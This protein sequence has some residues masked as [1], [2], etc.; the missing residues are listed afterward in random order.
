MEW[1]FNLIFPLLAFFFSMFGTRYLIGYLTS[2]DI[3]DR[4]NI[5]SS[6]VQPTPRGGGIAVMSSL[7]LIWLVV[8]IVEGAE[9]VEVITIVGISMILAGTSLLDDLKG[10]SASLRFAVHLF[11]VST[12]LYFVPFPGLIFGGIL[13]SEWDLI[14]TAVLWVW[15]INL[16]NF[17]DGI[18]GLASVEAIAISIGIFVIVRK[19]GFDEK[20][21]IL[22]LSIG[23]ALLGFLRWNWH[24]AKIFL[25]DVGSIPLGFVLGW[26]LL[27]LAANG[28]WAPAL[29]LPLYFLIDA[30]WTLFQ[31]IISR[32][33]L[34]EAHCQ[35]FYQR[36][37]A[38][39]LKHDQVS[40]IVTVANLFL[41]ML[42]I[43]AARGL[44]EAAV[45]AA[46]GAVGV[47]MF[48]LVKGGPTN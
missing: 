2:H 39:G 8:G 7:L 32:E 30:T 13:S 48:L 12:A 25:G 24:P 27:G 45:L 36:A 29:I 16:F 5:R 22:S 19:L 18:D 17:M 35:H 20:S 15:F 28:A 44:P 43:I 37:V 10:L 33:K 26:M 23:A 40:W 38:S 14:V 1:P 34:W 3:L 41:I 9:G 47:L 31:R 42:S 21:M 4:P 11:A 46:F 6:H